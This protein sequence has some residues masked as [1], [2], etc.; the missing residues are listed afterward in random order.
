MQKILQ[1]PKVQMALLLLIIFASV[2]IASFSSQTLITF[3]A[4]L[5]FT[6]VFDCV[7]IFVRLRKL[8]PPYAAIVT[9]CIIGLLILP[10]APIWEIAVVTF[11]AMASKNFLRFGGKHLFNPAAFGLFVSA[12]FF[13]NIVTWWGVSTQDPTRFTLQGIILFLILL[14]PFCISGLRIKRYLSS[15]AFYILYSLFNALFVH[16]TSF[17]VLLTVIINPMIIFFA[18]VMV[19]EPMTSPVRPPRQVF[20]GLLVAILSFCLALP[21]VMKVVT[22][23]DVFLAGLLLGNIVFFRFK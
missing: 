5:G 8:F 10:T 12:F 1:I 9:G 14:S 13:K 16:I 18:I 2:L 4:S 22:I 7:F 20:Y 11:L 21:L 6:L 17:S 19:P 3:L 23:P 15:F